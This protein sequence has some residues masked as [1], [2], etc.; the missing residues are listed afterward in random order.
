VFTSTVTI[1]MC[2]LSD[3]VTKTCLYYTVVFS[4]GTR[5]LH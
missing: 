5:K 1:N 3:V 2:I 4:G